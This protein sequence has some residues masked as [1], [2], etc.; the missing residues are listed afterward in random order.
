MI[1]TDPRWGTM[2]T[3]YDDLAQQ[4]VRSISVKCQFEFSVLQ[5]NFPY[6]MQLQHGRH[7]KLHRRFSPSGLPFNSSKVCKLSLRVFLKVTSPSLS[8]VFLFFSFLCSQ[9]NF[10]KNL[11]KQ[12]R[13][14]VSQDRA[15]DDSLLV[16]SV[17]TGTHKVVAACQ[18]IIEI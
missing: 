11:L 18:Q 14:I 4:L 8:I 10:C 3:A 7:F 9:V 1:T 15:K 17:P 6:L 13:Q 12:K 5:G 16:L 2:S